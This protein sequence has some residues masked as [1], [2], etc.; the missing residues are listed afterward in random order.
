MGDR[1]AGAHNTHGARMTIVWWEAGGKQP[2]YEDSLITFAA[3]L[4]AVVIVSGGHRFFVPIPAPLHGV[5]RSHRPS[6]LM[7]TF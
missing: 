1:I 4:V 5:I 2:L 6:C 7:V 3:T